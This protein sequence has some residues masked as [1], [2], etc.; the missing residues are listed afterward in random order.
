MI[1]SKGAK[2]ISVVIGTYN[3]ADI[4]VK[5]LPMWY[6]VCEDYAPGAEIII[7]DD[8]SHGFEENA[9]ERVVYDFIRSVTKYTQPPLTTLKDGANIKAVATPPK[10]P[11]LYLRKPHGPS[12]ELA[13]NL[14]QA[15]PYIRNDYTLVV[16][17]DSY[18]HLDLL[19][20]YGWKLDDRAV[21]SGVR[22]GVKAI[23]MH[24]QIVRDYRENSSEYKG[25]ENSTKPWEG[26][27]GNNFVIPSW[28]LKRANGFNE[29]FVGYG[30]EDWELAAYVYYKFHARFVPT[31][32]A[33]VYHIQHVVREGSGDPNYVNA[34]LFYE[35]AARYEKG[36]FDRSNPSS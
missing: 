36:N 28:I 16:M 14:N 25:L 18:P 3:Q 32:E 33:R 19:T 4:L 8:G 11:I 15:I 9:T 24:E 35:L 34:N 29:A 20:N 6:A 12:A 5:T 17:A 23:G 7:C 13:A 1:K 26:F 2:G 30:G 22:D 31:P 27:T 10:V 21:L